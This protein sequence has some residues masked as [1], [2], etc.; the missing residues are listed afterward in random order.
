[1]DLARLMRI[2]SILRAG[3]CDMLIA[4]D[5]ER[6]VAMYHKL[7]YLLMSTAMREAGLDISFQSP[8]SGELLSADA[9]YS[10][11]LFQMGV[12]SLSEYLW[13]YEKSPFWERIC[14]TCDFDDYDADIGLCDGA[15]LRSVFGGF[16]EDEVIDTFITDFS[17]NPLSSFSNSNDG[18]GE[19]GLLGLKSRLLPYYER[20][21]ERVGNRP[22]ARLI[23]EV[24]REMF[25]GYKSCY[26]KGSEYGYFCLYDNLDL[27]MLS[28]PNMEMLSLGGIFRVPLTL[29]IAG[30]IIDLAIF[31]LDRE[32][33][34]LPKDV[35]ALQKESI[36]SMPFRARKD[37]KQ[38]K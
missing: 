19:Q 26:L 36:I 37:R 18:A 32:E 8:D 31:A 33:E 21:R 35:R 30:M 12:I 16:F 13:Y 9:D 38:R 4:H 6:W 15:A 23:E 22:L 3:S 34:F 17:K 27:S 7:W 29:P 10:E 2:F 24:K 28:E 11:Y 25:F 20:N 1:M 5:T 14:I